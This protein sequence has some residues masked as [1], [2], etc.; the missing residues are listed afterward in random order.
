MT[1]EEKYEAAV[2]AVKAHNVNVYLTHYINGKEEISCR[3]PDS[4]HI[5]LMSTLSTY[6]ARIANVPTPTALRHLRDL[7]GE[8]LLTERK[9][10]GG[11]CTFYLEE[12]K[13]KEVGIS[14]ISD[15]RAKGIKFYDEE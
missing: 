3:A 9:T 7:V 15:M 2:Q 14:I 10:R 6:Y 12:D 11:S 8:G 1:L 5:S 4:F 13:S